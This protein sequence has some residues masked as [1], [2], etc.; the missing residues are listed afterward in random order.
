MARGELSW[1]SN[2][3][4]VGAPCPAAPRRAGQIATPEPEGQGEGRVGHVVDRHHVGAGLG[5]LVLE[6]QAL[7]VK[8]AALLVEGGG[9]GRARLGSTPGLAHLKLVAACSRGIARVRGASRRGRG[10]P[11]AA[12]KQDGQDQ[13]DLSKTSRAAPCSTPAAPPP[14]PRPRPRFMTSPPSRIKLLVP[15]GASKSKSK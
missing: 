15:S 10:A 12:T 9:G 2:S 1:A 11:P 8:G 13:E 5:L 6:G 3:T 4:A 7:G 14:L